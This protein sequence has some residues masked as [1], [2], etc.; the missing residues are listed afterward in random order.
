M[1][2]IDDK[3]LKL[4]FCTKSKDHSTGDKGVC[5]LSHWG[6]EH[7][8]DFKKKRPQD[9]LTM[10]DTDV[11]IEPPLTTTLEPSS[12]IDEYELISTPGAW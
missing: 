1:P 6:S 12:E 8:E 2:Y 3:K 9:N 4:M 7:N 5:D 10:V 11:P